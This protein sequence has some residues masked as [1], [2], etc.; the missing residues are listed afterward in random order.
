MMY[1]NADKFF[2]LVAKQQLDEQSKEMQNKKKQITKF[3]KRIAE[4][5]KIFRRI[6]E[7][8]ISGAISHERFFETVC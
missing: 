4:L 5:D 8:D 3:Q 1:D 6:Y 7:D 2:N